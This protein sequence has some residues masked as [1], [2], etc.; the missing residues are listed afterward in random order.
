[1]KG[2]ALKWRN[3]C[4]R[5]VEIEMAFHKRSRRLLGALSPHGR[6]WEAIETL[7]CRP[8]K[9]RIVKTRAVRFTRAAR[10]VRLNTKQ[11]S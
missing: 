4:F 5:I 8:V 6:I 9:W 11:N 1:M 7:A 2:Q 10:E 3:G